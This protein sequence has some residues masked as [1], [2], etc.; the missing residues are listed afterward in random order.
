MASTHKALAAKDQ[1]DYL[2][3]F[4][5]GTQQRDGVKRPR[6]ERRNRRTWARVAGWRTASIVERSFS[7]NAPEVAE[8]ATAVTGDAGGQRRGAIDIV[9]GD[10]EPFAPG[11]EGNEVANLMLGETGTGHRGP[12]SEEAGRIDA[13]EA[14]GI[15]LS[16]ALV[17]K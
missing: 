15:S 2:P 1:A 13:V 12:R 10:E 11:R 14:T 6:G 4:E 7:E 16:S 8:P 3:G 17:A 9:E 5:Q